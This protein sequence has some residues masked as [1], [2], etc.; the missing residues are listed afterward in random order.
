MDGWAVNLQV[1]QGVVHKIRPGVWYSTQKSNIPMFT[2]LEDFLSA[3]EETVYQNPKTHNDAATWKKK[4]IAN[5]ERHYKK[6]IKIPRWS[7]IERKYVK[8]S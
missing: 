4:F 6:K 3:I 8:S 2:C 1:K 5:Y 7:D